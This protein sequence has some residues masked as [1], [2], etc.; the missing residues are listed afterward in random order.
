MIQIAYL[1]ATGISELAPMNKPRILCLHGKFQ[2]SSIFSNKIAGARRKL[3]REYDLH[4][5]EGPIILTQNENE[6]NACD[7]GDDA[8]I[9]RGWWLRSDD[10]KHTMV[11]EA[12]E[13]V[14]QETANEKYDAI[15][16]FSQG[17]TL[18]TALALSGKMNGVRAVVTAGAPYVREAFDVATGLYSE[19]NDNVEN[20]YLQIPKLHM[21]GENDALVAVD[22]TKKLCEEG[23]NGKFILHEQGH[24][25]PTRSARVK[26]IMDFLQLSMSD[27]NC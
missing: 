3:A 6:S 18:A 14:I 17:G 2:S 21:A 23:G 1:L 22:S 25:F 5:L 9:P 10:G 12:F 13:Y 16:G 7:G 4:F 8:D 27:S 19:S 20:K 24:L 11:K 15:L 26:E